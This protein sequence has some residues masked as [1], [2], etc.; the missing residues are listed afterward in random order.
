ML[1]LPPLQPPFW[2]I[3]PA[4]EHIYVRVGPA[5]YRW[6]AGCRRIEYA[7]NVGGFS[8]DP[9]KYG[10][11]NNAIVVDNRAGEVRIG[12]CTRYAVKRFKMG[13]MRDVVESAHGLAALTRT[14]RLVRWRQDPVAARPEIRGVQGA[15][16]ITAVPGKA[17]RYLV[18]SPKGLFL[19]ANEK[20]S[21]FWQHGTAVPRAIFDGTALYVAAGPQLFR[22]YGGLFPSRVHTREAAKRLSDHERAAAVAVL[23][24][25]RRAQDPGL[26]TP[27]HLRGVQGRPVPVL[28][29]MVWRHVLD[30]AGTLGRPPKAV[31]V[32]TS[33]H[34]LAIPSWL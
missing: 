31:Q 8:D 22:V 4:S 33:S 21:L 17:E 30:L 1:F 20:A 32:A 5:L 12:K 16:T 11:E 28:P 2:Q 29:A 24:A 3:G 13:R 6:C 19:V 18:G 26:P 9:F 14:G 25:A 7:G 34:S 10:I 23:M 15:E 27:R